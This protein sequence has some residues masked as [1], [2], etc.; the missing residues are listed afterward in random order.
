MRIFI[1]ALQLY[2]CSVTWFLAVGFRR[3]TRLSCSLC[4]TDLYFLLL[5]CGGGLNCIVPLSSLFIYKN[6]TH[7]TVPDVTALFNFLA[8][9]SHASLR[10]KNTHTHCQ[11]LSICGLCREAIK[12]CNDATW[13]P[14]KPQRDED[15]IRLSSTLE[16]VPTK[17]MEEEKRR[18]GLFLEG[19]RT[20][21][22][23][24]GWFL[25]RRL[26]WYQMTER[27]WLLCVISC[28]IVRLLAPD[29]FGCWVLS[30]ELGDGVS[31]RESCFALFSH[32]ILL[33]KNED[34]Q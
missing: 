15:A 13:Q 19:E 14:I 30:E 26:T 9:R 22:R 29:W 34:T 23:M 32:F 33:K 4:L 2:S 28:V 21:F 31:I 20:L 18:G 10:P 12:V 8:A 5:D 6:N 7:L 24:S 17:Q 11:L 16:L 25:C 27:W 3:L 1:V